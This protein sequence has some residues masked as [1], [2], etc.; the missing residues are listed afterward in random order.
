MD[1][2]ERKAL[3]LALVWP[4]H[5]QQTLGDLVERLHA[6]SE[7]DH[8]QIWDLIDAWTDSEID[9]WAKAELRER[10]RRFAFTRRGRLR[11]L[12]DTTKE[13]A[14]IAYE[15][16]EPRDPI[17]RHS[18]LFAEHWIAASYDDIEDENY[19]SFK[20]DERTQTLR[21]CAMQEIWAKRG[22]D[23]VTALLSRSNAP[24]T[25]GQF[26]ALSITDA[27]LQTDFLLQC[28]SMTDDLESKF[29]F[30][31]HGFLSALQD[32][33][34]GAILSAVTE[35]LVADLILRLLRQAPF[36]QGTWRLL[37]QYDEEIRSRYWKEVI[38][39]WNR[40]SEAELNEIIDRLLQA[41]RP[42]A[43]FHVVHLDW[44]QIETARLK[45]LLL[46]VA[47]VSAE[48]VD[49]YRVD[50]YYIS[51]ALESLESRTGVSSDE[52][53]QLE[54]MYLEALRRSEHGIPNLERK[55]AESPAIFVQALA[56][57]FKRK[58]D[59]QDPLEWRIEDPDRHKEL[60][61]GAYSLLRRIERI[62]GTDQDNKINP[63][64]LLAWVIEVRR[65][66]TV[67][68]RAEIGD[69]K[70]GELLSKA[71]FEEDGEWPCLPVCEVMERIS[72]QQIG[73]GFTIGVYNGRGVHSRRIGEGGDQE[74]ELATKYWGWA[75]GR[76]I[77]YPFVSKVLDEI[78]EGY[79]REGRQYDNETRIQQRLGH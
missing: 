39:Y 23:G 77:D 16:L 51:E 19:D 17:V 57:A 35:G 1:E 52:M 32:D 67:H 4:R 73:L 45:R 22:F 33:V 41:N 53:A 50:E 6:I 76:A 47:T 38:P 43:A 5:D 13:R 15:K 20:H 42:R 68:G 78:A 7:N 8:I 14:P 71:P 12:N 31:M 27:S 9:E 36:G 2:F 10:I 28:L 24:A 75:R 26:L 72:S 58:D 63:D 18:W 30:C 11:G 37:D 29:D 70:I 49:W 40:H 60:A 79:E 34:R 61:G 21:T 25:V 74:R 62:P 54:F 59:G 3:N 55:I 56:L 64:L 65:L 69:Q 46:A 66:C 48:P 44:R